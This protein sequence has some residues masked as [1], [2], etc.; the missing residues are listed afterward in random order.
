[1]TNQNVIEEASFELEEKRKYSILNYSPQFLG[2]LSIDHQ[3][4]W[5]S[6]KYWSGEKYLKLMKTNF[7]VCLS[8]STFFNHGNCRILVILQL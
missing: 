5:L 3:H 6:E 4:I 1:M 7:D 8:L 2:G